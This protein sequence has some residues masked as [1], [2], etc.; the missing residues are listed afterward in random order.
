MNNLPPDNLS[1]SVSDGSL[2]AKPPQPAR[3]NPPPTSP[4]NLLTDQYSNDSDTLRF[5]PMTPLTSTQNPSFNPNSNSNSNPVLTAGGQQRDFAEIVKE[6]QQLGATS[7]CL[8]KWGNQGELFRFRCYVNPKNNT[9]DNSNQ[10]NNYKYQKFFQH[11]GNDQIHVME[12]VIKEI[13]KWKNR[14]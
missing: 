13:K 11:I 9:L 5:I 3:V 7:Y 4:S 1:S 14:E 10:T 2:V 6:L 8:E 12:H